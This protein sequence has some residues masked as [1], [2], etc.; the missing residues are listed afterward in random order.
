MNNQLFIPNKIKV[1]YQERSGTYTGKLAY[2][3]YYDSKNKLRK[4]ASW[5]GW[6]DKKIQDN[7]FDNVPTEGFVL[8]KKVGGYKSD[9]NHRATYARVYDPRGFEFEISVEN[10]LYILQ[11]TDCTKGKGLLGEFVYSWSGTD[12]I[13][14]PVGSC[15]YS[16]CK[17]YTDLQGKKVSAKDLIQGAVYE[18]KKQ[19]K[20][21]Y[22]GRYDVY[23]KLDLYSIQ[24][25][26]RR[27]GKGEEDG[28]R[29]YPLRKKIKKHVFC[30]EDGKNMKY[31]S[32]LDFLSVCVNS[33]PVE[34]FASFLDNF[35]NKP[36]SSKIIELKYQGTKRIV[37]KSSYYYRSTNF[38]VKNGEGFS[39]VSYSL[40]DHW[41]AVKD[42]S[43]IEK[44]T[45][46]CVYTL[47]NGEIFKTEN[48]VRQGLYRTYIEPESSKSVKYGTFGDL[49][50]TCEPKLVAVLENGKTIDLEEIVGYY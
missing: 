47:Q 45:N 18:T 19:E 11:E 29:C 2:V 7:D 44:E 30:D 49:K 6:R 13:L 9:W 16:K 39:K 20:L 24:R 40:R 46:S 22:L 42:D 21:I 8:N 35:K 17:V 33:T 12:L 15:E 37:K 48:Y 31:V 4:E 50:D 41:G 23:E 27:E 28:K 38:F 36:E 10:L 14:L 26:E 3:I 1:G 43:I 25:K 34:E 5:Q 32:S